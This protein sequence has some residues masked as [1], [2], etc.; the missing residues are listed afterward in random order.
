MKSLSKIAITSSGVIQSSSSSSS[1]SSR[2]VR[3]GCFCFDAPS[4]DAPYAR[5]EH[6]A[7]RAA[8]VA[9]VED[10]DGMAVG[11]YSYVWLWQ[12]AWQALA[13]YVG[14]GKSG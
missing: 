7:A 5:R 4:F 1:I 3:D 12:R 13:R 6:A 11:V 8:I 14:F 9:V 2:S 10:A